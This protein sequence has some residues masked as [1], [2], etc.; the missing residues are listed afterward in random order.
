[1]EEVVA[2]IELEE[3]P[4]SRAYIREWKRQNY[5][6]HGEEMKATQRAYYYK[7]KY[8]VSD[9]EMRKYKSMLPVVAK[10]TKQ[11]EQL[12]K[13]NPEFLKEILQKYIDDV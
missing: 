1:M 10:V 6:K 12:K 5:L 9:E 11:L 4:K 8:G 3:E 7:Y 13:S 2:E